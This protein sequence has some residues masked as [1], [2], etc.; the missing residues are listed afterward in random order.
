MGGCDEALE[1]ERERERERSD[2]FSLFHR[3]TMHPISWHA[4]RPCGSAK[5]L[6]DKGEG[7]QEGEPTYID[8]SLVPRPLPPYF[9]LWTRLHRFNVECRMTFM[10]FY[11]I[12]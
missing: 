11:I 2:V 12:F 9:G 5:Q 1:R 4:W 8:Y 6:P 3:H 7:E 10:F